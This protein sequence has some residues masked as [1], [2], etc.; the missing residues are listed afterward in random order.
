[1]PTL[2]RSEREVLNQIAATD[3]RMRDVVN[4]IGTRR[5]SDAERQ[6]LREALAAKLVSEG[7]HANDEPNDLGLLIEDVIDK[8][9]DF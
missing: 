1:M 8:V 9:G 2:S 5:L 3:Q 6:E 7:L 4:T